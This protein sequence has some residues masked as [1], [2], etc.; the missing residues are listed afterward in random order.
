MDQCQPLPSAYVGSRPFFGVPRAAP[1]PAEVPFLQGLSLVHYSAQHKHF[2]P[3]RRRFL[4]K[5]TSLD[6][7]SGFS[8]R[9]SSG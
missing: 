7:L 6:T 5:L 8:D 9:N 4:T 3:I 1:S 2:F